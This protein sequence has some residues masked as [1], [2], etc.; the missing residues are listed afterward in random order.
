MN[1]KE[2]LWRLE[3]GYC[4]WDGAGVTRQVV[5]G[6]TDVPLWAQLT[7]EMEAAAGV[8]SRADED[9]PTRLDRC[10]A[11]LGH[12]EFRSLLRDRSSTLASGMS[13]ASAAL[14]RVYV[15]FRGRPER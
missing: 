3:G 9:F 6:H 13:A 8:D 15:C 12:E 11:G 2:A 5:A 7:Q 14:V 4:L 1:V 10:D